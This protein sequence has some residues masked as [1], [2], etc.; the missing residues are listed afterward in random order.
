MRSIFLIPT[1]QVSSWCKTITN[2]EVS[3][4]VTIPFASAEVIEM[5][6]SNASNE[7]DSKAKGVSQGKNS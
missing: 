4:L 6:T 5:T 1:P 3:G 7:N 2:M